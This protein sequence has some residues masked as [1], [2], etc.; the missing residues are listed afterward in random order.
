MTVDY[1]WYLRAAETGS[2]CRY[3]QISGSL[4]RHGVGTRLLRPLQAHAGSWRTLSDGVMKPSFT[5]TL[6]K[7]KERNSLNGD[8]G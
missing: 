5:L 4:T 8:A 2:Y 1:C 3:Q 7:N 6:E